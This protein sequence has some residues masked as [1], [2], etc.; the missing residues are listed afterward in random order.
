MDD[1]VA[2]TWQKIQQEAQSMA[3]QEPMLASFFHS[4]ILNHRDL[5]SALS[6]QLANKL[7][8]TTMP[9]IALREVIELALRSEPELL[10]AVA[11]D[12]RAVQD[13]DPAVDLFSTPLL[14]LKG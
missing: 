14:Y 9:A 4:T 12:I 3:A 8:S 7:D 10:A 1:L 6:F 5:R 2:R 11:A 13:R